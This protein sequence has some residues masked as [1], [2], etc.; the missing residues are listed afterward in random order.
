MP[1]TRQPDTSNASTIWRG[2]TDRD[3]REDA[4]AADLADVLNQ[5]GSDAPDGSRW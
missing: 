1:C 4:V 2:F 5:P 3:A